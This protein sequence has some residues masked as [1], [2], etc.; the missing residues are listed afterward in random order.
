MTSRIIKLFGHHPAGNTVQPPTDAT[1]DSRLVGSKQGLQLDVIA[2]HLPPDLAV[3]AWRDVPTP[4]ER[5]LVCALNERALRETD[6]TTGGLGADVGPVVKTVLQRAVWLATPGRDGDVESPR[7]RRSS[8]SS[9]TREQDGIVKSADDQGLGPADP[10]VL[11]QLLAM[12][13]AMDEAAGGEAMGKRPSLRKAIEPHVQSESTGVWPMAVAEVRDRVLVTLCSENL[14][15]LTPAIGLLVE[16]D[17]LQGCCNRLSSIPRELGFLQNLTVLSLARNSLT[18]FP[19]PILQLR[20]LAEL[21]LSDN[22]ISGIPSA[23]GTMSS[24][25]SL[26]LAK[27]NIAYLPAS[28]G[29]LTQLVVLDV[30]FNP[31]RALPSSIVSLA[32]IKHFRID[33]CPFWWPMVAGP[34]LP[35]TRRHT[36]LSEPRQDLHVDHDRIDHDDVP[37]IAD[38]AMEAR[39]LAADVDALDL[40]KYVSEDTKTWPRVLPLREL[41]A[42]A[43]VKSGAVVNVADV[44]AWLLVSYRACTFCGG[45]Y[46]D[47]CARRY[48][49]VT[50]PGPGG[51]KVITVEDRLCVPHWNDEQ[52]RVAAMF[53]REEA[54]LHSSEEP[55]DSTAVVET[56]AAIVD[57]RNLDAAAN[58]AEQG[59]HSTCNV[60]SRA[61]EHRASHLSSASSSS[62]RSSIASTASSIARKSVRSLARAVRRLSSSSMSSVSPTAAHHDPGSD[63]P[64]HTQVS[65]Q[66]STATIDLAGCSIGSDQLFLP[67]EG[68]RFVG[69]VPFLAAVQEAVAIQL[70]APRV[71]VP[72]GGADH[73]H[74]NGVVN[75]LTSRLHRHGPISG[76]DVQDMVRAAA[77]TR[78]E[79][80]P[81][82]TEVAEMAA[83]GST[84]ATA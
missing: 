63:E 82:L 56:A 64:K 5:A 54:G 29:E 37:G 45:P 9:L 23:I 4:S 66:C 59:R 2:A 24:L 52:E 44:P 13:Q 53:T 62:R 75:K 39:A 65:R 31:L 72:L 68:V 30:E 26:A 70:S 80:V 46:F 40:P 55:V 57:A 33:G 19:L 83:E 69:T 34:E 48:R 58:C 60:V 35:P 17:V 38:A 43:L 14:V 73:Q 10:S 50:R 36:L 22:Q 42:R 41:A 7:R 25:L 21:D 51:L 11:L 74:H 67:P 32:H 78:P 18:E 81:W 3:L 20:R 47:V 77:A 1:M 6:L 61:V 71:S 28:L 79:W 8:L 16:A 84:A 76:R 15:D 49:S 27:N 12:S